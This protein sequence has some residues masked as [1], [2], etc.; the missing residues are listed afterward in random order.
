MPARA[1]VWAFAALSW[2]GVVQPALAGGYTD[3]QLSDAMDVAMHDAIFTLYHESGHLLIDELKLPVLGKEEDAADA[4]AI[5][6]ILKN[7]PDKNELTRTLDDVADEW[8][9]AALRATPADL[10]SYDRHS[11][12]IQRANAMMCMMVGADP[13]SFAKQAQARGLGVDDRDDCADDYARTLQSWT[14]VLAPHLAT[15]PGPEIKVTYGPADDDHLQRFADALRSRH[16]LER[17]AEQLRTAYALPGGLSIVAKECEEANSYYLADDHQILYCYELAGDIYRLTLDN[18]YGGG[19]AHAAAQ[20]ATADSTDV[21]PELSSRNE[22]E[23]AANSKGGGH[24][25]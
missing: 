12:D 14:A 7:T 15:R 2:S 10:T 8:Y 20:T 6:Q 24:D 9:F 13:A 3:K 5:I 25:H 18:R 19:A 11:L 21:T 16:I 17:V 1:A 23:H 4:L 22:P